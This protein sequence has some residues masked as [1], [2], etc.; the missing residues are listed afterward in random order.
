MK[1]FLCL[2]AFLIAFGIGFYAVRTTG[3]AD[4]LIGKI[5]WDTE[6]LE[7]Y[8]VPVSGAG[9]GYYRHCY[10]ALDETGKQAY[11]LILENV[12]E[13][14][15]KIRIPELTDAQLD[16]V[17]QALLYDNPDL[18]CLGT[19]CKMIGEGGKFYFVPV[20]NEDVVK[21]KAHTTALLKEAASVAAQAT[22]LRD[23]YQRELFVHDYIIARCTYSDAGSWTES[24]A[25]GALVLKKAS[26]GG[27]AQALQL[28][29]NRLSIDARLV[30]GNAADNKGVGQPHMWNAVV[31][32]GENYFL[33]LTWDDPTSEERETVSHIYFNVTGA[34][35]K[36]THS[37]IA[38][39]ISCTALKA[40]YFV[41][42][43]LYFSE[44]G[45]A[46]EKRA[47][48]AVLEGVAKGEKVIE[49]RFSN[50]GAYERGKDKIINGSLL[51]RA[52][53]QSGLIDVN[54]AFTVNYAESKETLTFTVML[55][56]T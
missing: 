36:A 30:W 22:P 8:T 33:D 4:E 23:A 27:Y 15:E 45:S 46:F 11:A 31:I 47:A 14:P 42:E 34:F 37:D 19:N 13:H 12:R 52:Y 38:P 24:S 1:K 3:V 44:A 35:L 41:K 26:C 17:F 48:A 16:D 54:A 18:L 5:L 21:C 49:F 6:E 9:T 55:D 50:A 40:N 7:K 51:R 29:L 43:G 32:G 10:A 2:L 39:D 20:Y 28:I 56:P 53:E 25:Y